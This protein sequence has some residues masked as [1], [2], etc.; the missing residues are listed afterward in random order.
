VRINETSNDQSAPPRRTFF[1]IR[2][3]INL[4][5]FALRRQFTTQKKIGIISLALQLYLSFASIPC[6]PQIVNRVVS[7][8]VMVWCM[9]PNPPPKFLS[10]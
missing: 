6:Q 10:G 8:C 9:T 4:E 5:S 2:T 3:R 7:V 1:Q